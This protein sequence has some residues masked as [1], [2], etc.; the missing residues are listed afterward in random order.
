MNRFFRG[1]DHEAFLTDG[2]P[3]VRFTE[4]NEDF[5]QYFVGN[6][7]QVRVNLSKDNVIFGLRAVGT[8]GKKSPAVFPMPLPSQYGRY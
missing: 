1:G 8:N 7:N 6:V 5:N 3:A 4:P 2:F